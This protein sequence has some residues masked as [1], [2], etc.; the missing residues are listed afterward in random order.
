MSPSA[1][2][3]RGRPLRPVVLTPEQQQALLQLRDHAP[4]P[5]LRER[6][7]AI[8]KLAEGHSAL[9]VGRHLLLRP[10]RRDTVYGWLQR[11]RSEGVA[12]LQIRAGRGRKPAFSPSVSEC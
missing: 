9:Q 3:R 7:A 11:F 5:Y 12:G 1:V 8:L 4:K 2:R 6:A 10:R